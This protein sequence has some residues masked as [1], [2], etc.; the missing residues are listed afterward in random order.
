[1][2]ILS[3]VI[4][5]NLGNNR[6]YGLIQDAKL[7]DLTF[8]E[9]NISSKTNI[10]IIH[11][12][13]YTYIG[14]GSIPE[15]ADIHIHL[16]VP[17]RVA[18]PWAKLNIIIPNQ[19]WWYKDAWSWVLK[20]KSAVFLFK[21]RYC[22][23]IFENMGFKGHY[24][25]WRGLNG[26]SEV[27]V[28]KKRQFLY[29]VGGSKSKR[30]AADIIVN[31]WSAD[32]PPLIIVS[33]DKGLT[34]DG[35]EWKT[36]Y[37]SETDKNNLIK[38]SQYHVVA[39]LAEG[40]GYTMMEAVGS[41]AQILWNDLPVYREHWASII[42]EAGCIKTS[43]TV[44]ISGC[45]DKY[46]LFS[47][48]DV[49]NA[50]KNLTNNIIKT[51]TGQKSFTK[52]TKK[53]REDF[54]S[55]WKTITR[56]TH[57]QIAPPKLLETCDL[58]VLGVVTLVHNRPEWF[59]HCVKN[60]EITDYPRD[61]FVWIVVDDSDSHLRV[62]SL[63]EKVRIGYPDLNIQ[64]I[65]LPKKTPI[66]EKRNRGC[67][68]ALNSRQD[69]TTFA[70]MDD[71]DHY[72][73]TSLRN[74]ITWLIRSKKGAVYCSTLPM[75]DICRYISAINVPPLYLTPGERLS[76]ATLCFTLDFWKQKGFPKTINIAEGEAFI[77]GRESETIEIPPEGIIVSFL[78]KK[79]VTSRRVPESNESNGC[80]YGFTNEYFE[81][82]S[83]IGGAT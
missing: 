29:I 8:R 69:L 52:M 58:P 71:D 18:F 64:Y 14:K 40:L 77:L 55:V 1:M 30:A 41:G 20:E 25:G 27:S 10:K 44:D 32:F 57:E 80:H 51:V 62:D 43:S 6:K 24:I 72:P 70:F 9:M 34:K 82:I 11:K 22:Q 7:L 46:Y 28:Q 63:I 17:C 21:T 79:N 81:M 50:V 15:K 3:V 5:S 31:A 23:I 4:F 42:G 73:T 35:V 33:S 74:R 12:D 76:E 68:M 83:N 39:S 36:G 54:L 78:H 13:P 66:G 56:K 59:S 47:E 49:V 75:Y 37:M 60:I 2:S 48:T 19:E 53:F 38:E 45:V 26:V 65:S 67:V 16:E 61:K